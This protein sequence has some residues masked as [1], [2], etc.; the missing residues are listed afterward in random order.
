MHLYQCSAWAWRSAW[1]G[2]A[3]DELDFDLRSCG[4]RLHFISRGSDVERNLRGPVN[5]TAPDPVRNVDYTHALDPWITAYGSA[6]GPT[7]GPPPRSRRSC[8]RRV[9]DKLPHSSRSTDAVW[10]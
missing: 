6:A 9:T 4:C 5:L 2:K 10:I 1:H 8:R 7:Y 3:V